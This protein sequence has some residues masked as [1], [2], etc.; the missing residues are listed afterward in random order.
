[1]AITRIAEKEEIKKALCEAY[2]SLPKPVDYKAKAQKFANALEALKNSNISASIKNQ[3]LKDIIERIDYERPPIVRIT[4]KNAEQYKTEKA[5]GL[6]YH[7]EPYKMS[8]TLKH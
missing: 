5:K 1:M 4:K 3:Y 6:Q 2:E 7:I 8:I